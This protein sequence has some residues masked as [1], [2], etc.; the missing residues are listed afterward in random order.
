MNVFDTIASALTKFGAF[1]ISWIG[2][3]MGYIQ[4]FLTA[5]LY[6]L[7]GLLRYLLETVLY[8]FISMIESFLGALHLD[9]IYSSFN[10]LMQSGYGYYLN[11]FMVPA[12][13]SGLLAA[14]FIKFMIRRLP[15]V[16]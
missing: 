1:I 5:C 4:G 15:V 2:Y 14:F 8:P 10:S 11:Y 16:G 12:A 6:K 7:Y 3:Y 13:I 9:S